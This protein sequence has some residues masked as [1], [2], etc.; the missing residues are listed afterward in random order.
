MLS[1][2]LALSLLSAQAD[3]PWAAKIDG[4]T[5]TI[6]EFNTLY[7][8]RNMNAGG[9]TRDE[10]DAMA[11]DPAET[12]KNPFLDRSFFLD[13]LIR[14][15]VVYAQAEKEGVT[16]GEEY[17]L[18]IDVQ[19]DSLLNAYYLR[20]KLGESMKVSLKEI[21]DVY[22]E[23]AAQ[24]D[25]TSPFEAMN[26]IEK[27]L[28]QKKQRE[29]LGEFIGRLREESGIGK[30]RDLLTKLADPDPA[31]RPSSGWIA[32]IDGKEIPVE[33]FSAI[34]YAYLTDQYAPASRREIDAY[35]A[36]PRM[37]ANNPLLDRERF[38]DEIVNQRL[39]RAKAIKDGFVVTAEM[40][41]EIRSQRESGMMLQYA[42]FRFGKDVEPTSA[43]ID[44]YYEQ[45]REQLSA[46]P[47]DQAETYI[48]LKLRSMKLSA[49]IDEAV[50]A[51]VKAAVIKRNPAALAPGAADGGGKTKK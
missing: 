14:Q 43:E 24:F 3:T 9:V 25:G 27:N 10:V 11:K 38:L 12:E 21:A 36:D 35:A 45:N 39:I 1:L 44:A 31:K 40:N 47:A 23:N 32:K 37:A 20:A 7:Y 15:R 42:Q 4:A 19:R 46:L 29:V 51:L 50:D 18:R 34:Y 30:N 48:R 41:A 26:Y 13:R 6:D 49:K 17:R 16:K 22:A 28:A 2:V 33:E 8:A 5:I